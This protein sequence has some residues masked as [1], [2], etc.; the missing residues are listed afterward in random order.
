MVE[1]RSVR[2]EPVGVPA[3]VL[4]IGQSHSEASQQESS[5][6]H[7][8]HITE[9]S[10]HDKTLSLLNLDRLSAVPWTGSA[11]QEKVSSSSMYLVFTQ[12]AWLYA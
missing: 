10:A 5:S 12:E 2:T 11:H 7:L 4:S 6:W 8:D 1:G 9:G 3:V